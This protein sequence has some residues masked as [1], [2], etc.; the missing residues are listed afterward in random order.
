MKFLALAIRAGAIYKSV[1]AGVFAAARTIFIARAGMKLF[2]AV[3][4]QI[5]VSVA[6]AFAAVDADR[7]PKKLIYTL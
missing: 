7:R 6:N 1:P 4:A 3:L 2:P 5:F